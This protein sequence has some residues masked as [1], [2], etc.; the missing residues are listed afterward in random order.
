LTKRGLT[1]PIPEIKFDTDI[2]KKLKV[3][4]EWTPAAE[5]MALN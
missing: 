3:W 5:D 2:F 4:N 1:I